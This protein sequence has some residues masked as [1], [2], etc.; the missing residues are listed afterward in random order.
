MQNHHAGYESIAD[1]CHA[2]LPR[3]T[4]QYTYGRHPPVGHTTH[5]LCLPVPVV[6]DLRF[7]PYIQDAWWSQSASRG[8]TQLASAKLHQS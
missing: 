2:W 8:L 3:S 7:E 4:P 1:S 5:F 6:L